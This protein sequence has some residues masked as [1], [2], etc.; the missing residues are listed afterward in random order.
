M[1]PEPKK[2]AAAL[3]SAFVAFRE[4][5][6]ASLARGVYREAITWYERALEFEP[7]SRV[8]WRRRATAIRALGIKHYLPERTAQPANASDWTL[9]AGALFVLRQFAEAEYA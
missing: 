8:V 1:E 3:S 6:D 4:L 5:S 2:D 7:D 9:L